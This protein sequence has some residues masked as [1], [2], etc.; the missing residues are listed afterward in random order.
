LGRSKETNKK[1]KKREPSKQPSTNSVQQKYSNQSSSSLCVPQNTP[2][3]YHCGTCLR[4][5]RKGKHPPEK[6]R[7]KK[8]KPTNQP[9]TSSSSINQQGTQNGLP[10]K[11]IPQGKK[12]PNHVKQQQQQQI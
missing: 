8:E 7:P 3:T 9:K 11:E 4:N 2:H 6:N 10:W 5:P 1:Q 12:K